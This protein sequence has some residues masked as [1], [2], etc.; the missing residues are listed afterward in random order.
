MI[1]K[2]MPNLRFRSQTAQTRS[3]KTAERQ[4][5]TSK[6]KECHLPSETQSPRRAI[7]TKYEYHTGKALNGLIHT[8]SGAM[9]GMNG[10]TRETIRK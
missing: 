4:I 8:Q 9:H 3:V 5:S 1:D 7:P 6:S 10:M 2:M